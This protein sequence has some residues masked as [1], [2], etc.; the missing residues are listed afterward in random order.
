M[1][2]HRL[3]LFKLLGFTVH[4]DSSWIFIALLVTWS[5]ATGYFPE[6]YP[7]L[8]A[9]T[10]WA[11]GVAGAIGLFA[12]IIFHEFWHS[13]VARSKG[14]PMKGITLFLFGGVAETGGEPKSPGVEF[15]MA[16]AGP[17]ASLVLSGAAYLF[18]LG[19]RSLDWGAPAIG[20]LGY[21]AFINAALAVFNLLPA[22][23]LDGGRIL[24]AA[25][26]HWKK[27]LARATRIVANLGAGFG[28]ALMVLGGLSLL[29][30]SPIGGLWY[31]ILGLFLRGMARASARGVGKDA[32]SR[33]DS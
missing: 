18:Y 33:P 24:R 3:K 9:T 27:D 25:L 17:V 14:L 6:R 28:I 23:P 12:S 26:W 30:G 31:F 32:S 16:L 21:L 4:I 22:F 7:G 5:L 15:W 8:A 20:V 10:Y 29:Y 13:L 2:R 1:F 19:S 11:M